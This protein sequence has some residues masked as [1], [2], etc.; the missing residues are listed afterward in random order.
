MTSVLLLTPHVCLSKTHFLR[1]HKLFVTKFT[2]VICE[3]TGEKEGTLL[4]SAYNFSTNKDQ[5][6]T[7]CCAQ[8][9]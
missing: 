4:A 3:V 9:L 2:V 7:S 5:F 8:Q 6:V 1:N